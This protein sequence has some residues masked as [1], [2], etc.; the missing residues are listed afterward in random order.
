MATATGAILHVHGTQVSSHSLSLLP[1]SIASPS[2]R[3]C[4]STYLCVWKALMLLMYLCLSPARLSCAIPAHVASIYAL[5]PA[6]LS[7][8]FPP[9]TAR[10]ARGLRNVEILGLKQDPYLR[11]RAGGQV[12]QTRVVIDGGSMASWNQ[13]FEIPIPNVSERCVYGCSC[14]GR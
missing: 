10:H 8:A 2:L 12:F 6:R 13:R 7:H 3:R 9:T 4:Q 11:L 5:L 1:H 14:G